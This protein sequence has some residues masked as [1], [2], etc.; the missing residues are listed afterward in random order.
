[1]E[2]PNPMSSRTS[3][4]AGFVL[5]LALMVGLLGFLAWRDK[6]AHEQPQTTPAATAH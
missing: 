1:M 3:L 2:V 6:T 4:L 5:G